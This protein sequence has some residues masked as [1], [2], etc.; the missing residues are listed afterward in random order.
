M[1]NPAAAAAAAAR[2]PA[3]P[4]AG[5]RTPDQLLPAEKAILDKAVAALKAFRHGAFD[6]HAGKAGGGDNLGVSVE[7]MKQ[8]QEILRKC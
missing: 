7:E 1:A 6:K 4:E 8:M 2:L 5:C 3:T